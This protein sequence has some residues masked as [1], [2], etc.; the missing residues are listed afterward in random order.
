MNTATPMATSAGAVKATSPRRNLATLQRQLF[1]YAQDL[2]DLMEQQ[3]LLQRRYQLVLQ[4]HGR[5]NQSADVL[6][7]AIPKSI[8]AYLV[9]DSQGEIVRASPGAQRAFASGGPELKG[10]FIW[11]Y[12]HWSHLEIVTTLL[13][14]FVGVGATGA[15]E[16]RKLVL[17]DSTMQ[18]DII[19]DALV[20]PVRKLDRLEMFWL[21]SAEVQ[22]GLSD[23]E[24]QK[25]MLMSSDCAEGLL[26]CDASGLVRSVNPAFS[27]ITGYSA[28]DMVGENPRLLSSGR[29]DA[30][31]YRSFWTYL[32]DAGSWT[33]EF[34]NRK[35]NGHIYAEWKSVRAVKNERDETVSYISAIVDITHRDSEAQQ[36]ANLAY[37]DSLTGLPNRRLLEDRLTQA[38]VIASREASNFCVMYIDLDKFKPINDEFGHQVGDL[39]LLEVSARL[40]ATVRHSDMVARVGGDEFVILLQSP[41]NDEDAYSIASS[42]LSALSAPIQLPDGKVLS[43]SVSMGGARYPIDGD[44]VPTLLQNADAAMYGAKRFGLD[45]SFFETGS[46]VHPAPDLGFEIWKALERQELYLLYQPQVTPDKSRTVRGCEV[47][48]RW[49]HA[50]F[51][52]LFPLTFIPIAERNGAIVALGYWVLETAC[53]QLSQWQAGGLPDLTLSVNISSRQLQD[54][55]FAERVGQI[56]LA[57]G[58]KPS[59]LELEISEAD[60]MQYLQDGRS[61]LSQLREMAVKIAI[62]DFGSGYSSL[63]RLASLPIHRLKIDQSF[64]RDLAQSGEARAI[65]DCFIGVAA[66][67]G[68]QVTAGGVESEAQMEVLASQGCNLVQGYLTGKPMS[69]EAFLS[70]ALPSGQQPP[71]RV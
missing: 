12:I 11:Q 32:T 70:W 13:A 60:A 15:V 49:K 29:Q 16:Q 34:F 22:S 68:M 66:A 40:Q 54:P 51:G 21:L 20:M 62:D 27:R 50:V 19:Y 9:T 23:I 56:L 31:F 48:L 30:D 59:S 14:K 67:M 1:I 58:I 36:L 43:I 26:I 10:K 3:A 57:H 64:V 65:S 46:I 53:Q 35:K 4:S 42:V 6:L 37:H 63:S 47:L 69:A 25:L 45:F 7:D 41:V 44:D 33:G 18:R 55:Q 24:I 38:M 8:D 2:R 39:V 61:R 52:D 28:S 71:E 5:S 17:L